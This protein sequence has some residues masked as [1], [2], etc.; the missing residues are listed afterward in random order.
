MVSLSLILDSLLLDEQV[1]IGVVSQNCLKTHCSYCFRLPVKHSVK[2][3]AN[4]KI[5]YYCSE[6]CQ[7]KDWDIHKSECTLFNLLEEVPFPLMRLHVRALIKMKASPDFTSDLFNSVSSIKYMFAVTL[8]S[9]PKLFSLDISHLDPKLV[10]HFRE[11]GRIV[12]GL[13]PFAIPKFSE[14]E[15]SVIS[16][17]L[18]SNS[19]SPTNEQDEMFALLY[20]QKARR[21]NHSCEPNAEYSCL[22]R[23]MRIMALNPLSKGDEVLISYVD[24]CLPYEDRHLF[25]EQNFFFDC[26][27]SAACTMK[28]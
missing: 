21:L 6:K 23:N 4:C 10:Q 11:W 2:K 12:S 3:C 20:F 22:D 5:I 17:I 25:I 19:F 8:L 18:K 28:Q 7:R 13:I 15:H 26:K 16:A 14:D 24:R 1:S 27:C 9:E